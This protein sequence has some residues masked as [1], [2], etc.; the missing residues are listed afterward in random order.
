MPRDPDRAQKAH[1]Q[2]LAKREQK[3]ENDQPVR[4]SAPGWVL[5]AQD[6]PLAEVLLSQNWNEQGRL[7][8]ILVAR[9]SPQGQIASADFLV[10]LACLGA[11]STTIHLFKTQ[12]EYEQ[13][14]R[15]KLL[16]T[17]PMAPA[18]PN[19]V[20]K[21]LDTSVAYAKQ[22]GF[23]PDPAPVY[24]QA[25]L[26]LSDARPEACSVP[27]PTGGPEGKPYFVAGPYDDVPRIMAKLTRAAGPDG[28]HY[29]VM[30]GDPEVFDE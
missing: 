15:R 20:A 9:R 4:Y 23:D 17:Q 14:R 28:F 22:W 1:E 18:D 16:E 6:W 3:H 30:A 8:T 29:L 21:I 5:K 12:R 11:K 19:L 25:R 24:Y 2:K 7:I 10:D 26:L 13:T 27:V